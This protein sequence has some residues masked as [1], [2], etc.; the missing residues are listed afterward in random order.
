[1]TSLMQLA[2]DMTSMSINLNDCIA[3][4]LL[5]LMVT[6]KMDWHRKLSR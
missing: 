3:C 1:M 5:L 6:L 2:E 4:L